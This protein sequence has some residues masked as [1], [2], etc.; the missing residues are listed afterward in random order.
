M[1]RFS[2]YL[3]KHSNEYSNNKEVQ[4]EKNKEYN[5]TSNNRYSEE[6][7]YN[8]I[9]K[10]SNYTGNELMR[11]FLKLTLEKKK[12]GE[13][14]NKAIATL[15]ETLTPMLNEEQKDNLNK[16]LEMVENVK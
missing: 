13:L 12:N 7:L 5:K 3:N 8:M 15:K 6:D 11:E 14:D 16:I 1:E 4:E 10:Y 9:E 2:D